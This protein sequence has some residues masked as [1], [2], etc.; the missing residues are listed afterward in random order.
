AWTSCRSSRSCS[1]RRTG[2]SERARR[3]R[4]ER[5]GSGGSAPGTE[6]E[7]SIPSPLSAPAPALPAP[8][9]GSVSSRRPL[10]RSTPSE[11]LDVLPE[12]DPAI[13]LLHPAPRRLVGPGRALAPGVVRTDVVELDA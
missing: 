9:E 4:A 11:D 7:G 12:A 2:R 3:S 5:S 13:D 8:R 6:R 10:K 1:A